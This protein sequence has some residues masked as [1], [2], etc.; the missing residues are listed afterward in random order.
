[1]I[2]QYLVF[3]FVWMEMFS[4]ARGLFPIPFNVKKCSVS[5]VALSSLR[6][7]CTAHTHTHTHTHTY[8]NQQ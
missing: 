4:C 5:S 7:P 3:A 1:M 8:M 6:K 2:E